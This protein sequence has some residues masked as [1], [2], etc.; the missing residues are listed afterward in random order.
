M[1]QTPTTAYIDFKMAN[2]LDTE[3]KPKFFQLNVFWIKL[4]DFMD[5]VPRHA[6][7]AG[8]KLSTRIRP[9]ALKDPASFSNPST[10]QSA[11]SSGER[12]ETSLVNGIITNG[13]AQG[14]TN[15]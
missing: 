10:P 14:K 7:L 1:S 15:T 8:L 6:H 12:G 9:M 3:T 2:E 13:E 5:I 11:H 4:S